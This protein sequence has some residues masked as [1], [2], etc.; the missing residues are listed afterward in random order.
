MILVYSHPETGDARKARKLLEANI[1][2]MK[3]SCTLQSQFLLVKLVVPKYHNSKVS[4][5]LSYIRL[6]GNEKEALE[7]LQ[8]IDDSCHK[9]LELFT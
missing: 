2:A 4:P 8:K 5:F 3:V 9:V 6:V 1:K 7:S